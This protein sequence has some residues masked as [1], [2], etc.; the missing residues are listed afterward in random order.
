MIN[1]N[2]IRVSMLSVL[3]TITMAAPLV[4]A[5][6]INEN[7]FKV[8]TSETDCGFDDPERASMPFIMTH[9]TKAE[10][11]AVVTHG[12]SDSP[13]FVKDIAATLFRSGMNIVAPRLRGHGTSP[14]DLIT[15]NY[16]EWIVDHHNAVQMAHSLGDK[17]VLSGFSMGGVLSEIYAIENKSDVSALILISPANRVKDPLAIASC[18]GRHLMTYTSA[19]VPEDPV[20]TKVS[21][22]N[23][24]VNSVCQLNNLIDRL[25]S[26]VMV[27]RR[28]NIPTLTFVTD[29]DQT[30]NDNSTKKFM[31]YGVT[32]L[33]K[34]TLILSA[35]SWSLGP[36]GVN[37]N[38]EAVQTAPISHGA[39][40]M[41]TNTF[42]PEK[43]NPE[44][45]RIDSAIAEFVRDL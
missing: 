6:E 4:H 37:K 38:V 42:R 34:K 8:C 35:D 13:Y 18:L 28:I 39:M 12:L 32:S 40:P 2:P 36:Y 9:G 3:A 29:A 7:N 41:R 27:G 19:E 21:Y 1:L 31:E 23:M 20:G 11:V 5:Y 10:F 22:D 17:L 33:K 25:M 14:K 24:A 45:N 44:Y 26:S 30:V 16:R 15:V 43:V